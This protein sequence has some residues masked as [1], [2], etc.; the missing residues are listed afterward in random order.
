MKK[1]VNFLIMVTIIICLCT[2]A[3]AATFDVEYDM[4]SSDG[5]GARDN[6]PADYTQEDAMQTEREAKEKDA[7]ILKWMEEN[8]GQRTKGIDDVERYTIRVSYLPQETTYWCGPAS[9]QQSLSFHK[10][11]SDSSEKLPS[12]STLAKK[13]NTTKE[14]AWTESLKKAINAYAK[15]YDFGKYVAADIDG[16]KDLLERRIISSLSNRSSAPILL[17]ERSE[18]SRYEGKG[19]H[20]YVTVSGYYYEYATGEKRI[21][22]VDPDWREEKYGG[23][24]W[25][26]LNE[27]FDAVCAVEDSGSGNKV[28]L[29]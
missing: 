25:D 18:L 11:E 17:I 4:D 22:D 28:M 29:Y 16:S 10:R 7:Q 20:H 8:R 13:S 21:R 1:T 2:M 9:V 6:P 19:G 24:R 23:S 3:F 15:T 26:P 5:K 14:G 12:Q 27:I